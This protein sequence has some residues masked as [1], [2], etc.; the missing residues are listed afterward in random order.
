MPFFGEQTFEAILPELARLRVLGFC[1]PIG[2]EEKKIARA[3]L[4]LGTIIFM[5]S[6]K[7]TGRPPTGSV[8]TAPPGRRIKP[9]KMA[10]VA[11]FK[12]ARARIVG[13]V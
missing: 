13:C 12:C 4:S 6:N 9:G 7:P 8:S 2:V 10:A 11:I 3:Q 1:Y 5:G